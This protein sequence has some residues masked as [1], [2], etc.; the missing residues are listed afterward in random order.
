MKVNIFKSSDYLSMPW[1]NGQGSTLQLACSHT[2][3]ND[4]D[5]RISVADVEYDGSFSFFK[6]KLRIISILSGNGLRLKNL[7]D[8]TE[9]FLSKNI[10]YKF[11]GNAP[12]QSTLQNGAIRDFNLI[13]R[14]E[15]YHAEMTWHASPTTKLQVQNSKIFF[16]FNAGESALDIR[17]NQGFYT[18][19]KY[20][21]LQIVQSQDFAVEIIATDLSNGLYCIQLS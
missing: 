12:I 5:W 18:L 3:L 4:F 16:I 6:N 10:I 17:L 1:K 14:P 15:R 11:S 8:G 21:L 7:N 19:E 20:E 13:Y 2:D 9:V